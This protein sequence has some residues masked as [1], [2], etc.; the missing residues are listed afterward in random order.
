MPEDVNTLDRFLRLIYP[1]THASLTKL[2]DIADILEAGRKYQAAA[3]NSGI[4]MRH[5]SVCVDNSEKVS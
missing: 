4:L 2:F 1:V 5:H 3:V